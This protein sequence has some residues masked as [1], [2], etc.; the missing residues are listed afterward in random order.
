MPDFLL[1]ASATLGEG[2]LLT[3]IVI[4]GLLFLGTLGLSL[5]AVVMRSLHMR[6][7]KEL[8]ELA[9]L[10]LRPVLGAV[11]DP[12]QIPAVQRL[13]EE[14]DQV[15]FLNFIIEYTRRV[16]GTEREVLRDLARPFLPAILERV[17]A[18]GTEARAWAVQVLGTLGLPQYERE[19]I[20][21]LDDPTPLV[22]MIAARALA[23]RDTPQYAPAV[24]SHMDRFGGWS[25]M[26]LASMLAAM[27]P[28]VSEELRSMLAD[29]SAAPH[30]RAVMAEALL[31]QGDFLAGDPAA[32][33]VRT[34]GDTEL[35]ASC[36]RLLAAVGRPEHAHLVRSLC[37]S[38]DPVVRAQALRALGPLGDT[39]DVPVLIEAMDDEDPW[40]ALY[41][42]RGARD[43]GG[44]ELL[45][46]LVA[47]GSD[48][49]RLAD[50]VLHEEDGE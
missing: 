1:P 40:P 11:A 23:R 19:V 26:F 46:G 32:E 6:R 20:D 28:S 45:A 24:L 2:A 8:A 22:A 48:V 44:R 41:A 15:R 49:A 33:V 17:S 39:E 30:I 35:L 12:E 43:A 34:S 31:L 16:R 21:A 37:D 7:E 50:Q 36:L 4:V 27:G 5:Y 38:Q 29:E 3:L 14:E 10:W 25:K 13:V 18:R 47:S 9:D 42:A